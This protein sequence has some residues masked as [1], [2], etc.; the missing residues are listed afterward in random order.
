M[1]AWSNFLNINICEYK[2]VTTATT[3]AAVAAN[4][5]NNSNNNA[6]K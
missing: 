2:T 1:K 3:T 5:N 6:L 4:S